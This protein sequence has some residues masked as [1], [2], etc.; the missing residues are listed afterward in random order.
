MLM[1]GLPGDWTLYAYGFTERCIAFGVFIFLAL[2]DYL[3]TM[4][5]LLH[6][7]H[8]DTWTLVGLGFQICTHPSFYPSSL[9]C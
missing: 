5:S 1:S 4:G 2:L 8:G 7:A 3:D 6:L 9:L